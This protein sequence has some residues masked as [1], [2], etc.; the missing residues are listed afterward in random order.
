MQALLGEDTASQPAA[1]SRGIELGPNDAA[2]GGGANVLRLD[3]EGGGAGGFNTLG[4]TSGKSGPLEDPF[5]TQVG[6][7]WW[8]NVTVVDWMFFPQRLIDGV[9]KARR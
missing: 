7:F 2:A 8:H 3:D 6:C 9:H 4:L 5:V 1:G